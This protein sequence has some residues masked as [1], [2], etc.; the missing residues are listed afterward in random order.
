LCSYSAC[1]L[2][3]PPPSSWRDVEFLYKHTHT[4]IFNCIIF[5]LHVFTH[6]AWHRPSRGHNRARARAH[7]HTH[8]HTHTDTHTLIQ[9]QRRSGV[10]GSSPLCFLRPIVNSNGRCAYVC[11]LCVRRRGARL[12]SFAGARRAAHC[13]R[14][15]RH[16]IRVQAPDKGATSNVPHTVCADY[17]SICRPERAG[18][19]VGARRRKTTRRRRR[20]RKGRNI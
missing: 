11:V 14:R 7:T 10:M 17:R 3:L 19:T 1:L 6:T 15:L 12:R 5:Y 13:A 20:E 8:T 2:L 9:T 16:F 18:T 4:H